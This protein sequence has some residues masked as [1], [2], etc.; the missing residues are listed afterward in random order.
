MAAAAVLNLSFLSILVKWHIFSHRR[1]HYCKILF[2]Y[3]NRRL[4]YCCLCKD[5]RWRRRHLEL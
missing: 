5:L 4:S 2:I 1:L 3:V